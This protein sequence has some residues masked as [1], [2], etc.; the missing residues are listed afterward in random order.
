VV[1]TILTRRVF[2]I[3]IVPASF[4]PRSRCTESGER[5]CAIIGRRCRHAADLLGVISLGNAAAWAIGLVASSARFAPHRVRRTAVGH[6]SAMLI[7]APLCA[8]PYASGGFVSRWIVRPEELPV[9]AVTACVGG[10]TRDFCWAKE[11]PW[12]RGNT[13]KHHGRSA[14]G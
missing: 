7:A 8:A 12:L 10:A 9:G 13:V 6:S 1:S 3:C 5:T 14:H 4:S 2:C 11:T